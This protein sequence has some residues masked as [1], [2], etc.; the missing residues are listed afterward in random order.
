MTN[1]FAGKPG[2]FSILLATG[3]NGGGRHDEGY[4]L[5]RH[6]VRKIEPKIPERW[7]CNEHIRAVEDSVRVTI[8]CHERENDVAPLALKGVDPLKHSDRA[9][10]R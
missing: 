7:F 8:S 10:A 5:L 1:A 6:G 3:P 4:Y 9:L 2:Q